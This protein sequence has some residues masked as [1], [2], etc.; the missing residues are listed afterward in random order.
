MDWSAFSEP[1]LPKV[2]L[3]YPLTMCANY[4]PVTSMD[5]LLQYFGVVR[6]RDEPPH[7]VYPMG[8]APFIRL[9]LPG[10][11]PSPGPA[12]RNIVEDGIFRLVPDFVTKEAW[13]RKTY[14]ARSETV[15][16]RANYKKAW[17]NGQRCIIPAEAIYEPNYESGGSV[18]WRIRKGNG[19]PMGIAGIYR[20]WTNPAGED[21]VGMSMLTVNADDHPFMKQFHAPEDEKRMVVIL[22]SEDFQGWLTCPVDEA[23]ARYCKQWHGE[24]VGEPAALPKRPRAAPKAIKVNPKEPPGMGATGDLF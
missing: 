2:A 22:E 21:V 15:D 18:R 11:D 3:R 1:T 8:L 16:K 9:A 24:L 17:A 10:E 5:R 14:N 19:E 23:K 20:T 13:A 7:D 12:Q 4:V 6:D